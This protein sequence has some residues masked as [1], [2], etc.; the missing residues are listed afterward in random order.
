MKENKPEGYTAKRGHPP[1]LHKDGQSE[2][3]R[4]S[5]VIPCTDK[6]VPM[7][8]PQAKRFLGVWAGL[9]QHSLT[10]TFKRSESVGCGLKKTLF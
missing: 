9:Q 8:D 3:K 2:G 6:A 4:R 5:G 7:C 1:L 10:S